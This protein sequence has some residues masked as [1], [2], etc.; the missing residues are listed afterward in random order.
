[1]LGFW[2]RESTSILFYGSI[3]NFYGKK[4]GIFFTVNSRI[5]NTKNSYPGISHNPFT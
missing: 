3:F 4:E 2:V 5:G 1:M